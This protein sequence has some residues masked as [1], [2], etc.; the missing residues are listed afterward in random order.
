MVIRR[1]YKRV[2][3]NCVEQSA[4]TAIAQ[5]QKSAI[6]GLD[7]AKGEIVACL[8]WKNGEF[9]RPWSVINPSEIKLLVE[10]SLSLIGAGLDLKVAMESTGTYGDAVRYALTAVK[11]PVLRVSGKSV[12]DYKEIFDGVP[13]QH[14]GKDAAMIAELCSLGKATDWPFTMASEFQAE[15]SLVVR[16]MDSFNGE[17][18]QWQGR[19]EGVLA[20]S[21]PEL[22]SQLKPRNITTMKLLLEYGSPSA[23]GKCEDVAA[24]LLAWGRGK[25]TEARIESIIGSA[26]STAGIPMNIQEVKWLQEICQR[27]LNAKREVEH[28][29]KQLKKQF[30]N[31]SFWSSYVET[32]GAGTLGAILTSVWA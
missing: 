11:I 18:V 27:A 25:L 2:K 28:C 22:G 1:A 32:V 23:V 5:V 12:S 4:L 9:E 17:F 24:K 16:R 31:D 7:V 6:L 20:R 15:V 3:V 8:R 21:W 13:S 14:D 29:E 10:L 26:Q 19:L 30:G